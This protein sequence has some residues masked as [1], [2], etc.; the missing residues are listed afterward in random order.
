[1][2]TTSLTPQATQ[3]IRMTFPNFLDKL[4]ESAIKK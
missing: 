3:T 4:V 1:M 2:T